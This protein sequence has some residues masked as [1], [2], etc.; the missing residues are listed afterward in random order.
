MIAYFRG[1]GDDRKGAIRLHCILSVTQV[2]LVA[3]SP[4]LHLPSSTFTQD[5]SQFIQ[6]I[7]TG[8]KASPNVTDVA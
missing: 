5:L 1:G 7:Y 8:D 2:S 6:V 3:R 4:A